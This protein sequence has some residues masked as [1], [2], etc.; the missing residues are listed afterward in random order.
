MHGRPSTAQAR[1]GQP[2]GRERMQLHS[3]T[4]TALERGQHPR[5]GRAPA[6]HGMHAPST[7]LPGASLRR[8]P[9][10]ARHCE[11]GFGAQAELHL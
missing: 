7:S 4:A 9:K 5:H 6:L 8:C 3:R 2:M 11:R 10:P 1:E